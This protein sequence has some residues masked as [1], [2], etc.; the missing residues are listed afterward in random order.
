[1]LNVYKKPHDLIRQYEILTSININTSKTYTIARFKLKDATKI[2]IGD[3]AKVYIPSLDRYYKGK[4]VAIGIAALIGN[5]KPTETES[6]I[7]KDIPVKIEILNPDEKL[8]PGIIA[9]VEIYGQ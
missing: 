4:V 6:Y 8:I 7:R 5:A 3:M 2:Y 9:E 1:V